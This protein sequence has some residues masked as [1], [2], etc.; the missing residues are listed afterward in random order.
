MTF[1][2]VDEQTVKQAA[3]RGRKAYDWT[4][5]IEQLYANPN[6]WVEIERKV[7][8][9]TVAYR[10]KEKYEGIET[11]CTGGNNLSMTHPDKKLWTVYMRFVPTTTQEDKELF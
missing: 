9:S 1:K 4:S 8:F 11:V 10:L 6:Q 2:F 3:T 5:I 7:G